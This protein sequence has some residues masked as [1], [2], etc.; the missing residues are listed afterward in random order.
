[1]AIGGIDLARAPEVIAAGADAVA[2]ITDVLRGDPEVRTR[3]Y[4]A[5]LR[6]ARAGPG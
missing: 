4:L 6:G 5:A 2:V 1:V 3:E